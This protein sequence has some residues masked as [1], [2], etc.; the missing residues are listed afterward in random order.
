MSQTDKNVTVCH[1]ETFI[2]IQE[3]ATGKFLGLGGKVRLFT[4]MRGPGQILGKGILDSP[5]HRVV[6]V[7]VTIVEEDNGSEG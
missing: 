5:T 1:K 2:A 6:K 7:Q 4:N 3:K